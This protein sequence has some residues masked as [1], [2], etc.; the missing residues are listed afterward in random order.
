[1]IMLGLYHSG[2]A[3]ASDAV[4][5]KLEEGIRW[6]EKAAAAGYADAMTSLGFLYLSQ[7]NADAKVVELFHKAAQQGKTAAMSALGLLY[8]QGRGV[9]RNEGQS[10]AWTK[11]AAENDDKFAAYELSDMYLSGRGTR[12]DLVEA[13]GWCRNAAVKGLAPAMYKLSLFYGNGVGVKKDDEQGFTWALKAAQAGLAIA[14]ADV[15][16]RYKKGI[17]VPTD[18]AEAKRWFEAGEKAGDAKAMFGL[19]S[20]YD[21]GADVTADPGLAADWMV[22]AIRGN[23]YRAIESIMRRP[24]DWSQPF[25]VE[26]QKRLHEAGI[27]DGPINGEIDAST[28]RAIAALSGRAGARSPYPPSPS[29]TVAAKMPGRAM[30]SSGAAG[31]ATL[32]C[33]RSTASWHV[34]ADVTECLDQSCSTRRPCRRKRSGPNPGWRRPDRW[35]TARR[36]R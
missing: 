17:G 3:A 32:R 14:M 1:M 29:D 30:P 25:R 7:G 16:S 9:P 8:A 35:P 33:P 28:R 26:L 11:K 6:Y 20:L 19:S 2:R 34:V 23:S 4:P 27:Y 13:V 12:Q 36:P 31:T 18:L 5:R 22:R 10:F 24:A 15:G 21:E